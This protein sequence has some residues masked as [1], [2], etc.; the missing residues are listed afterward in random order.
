MLLGIINQFKPDYLAACYDLA[1][2]TFRKAA[3]DGYKAGRKKADEELVSQMVRSRDIF[4]AFGIPIYEKGGFEAD[5]IIGTIVEQTK[6]D[7][8]L[9][10]VIAS[11]DHDTL[12]LVDG[13]RVTVFTLKKGLNDTILY[14]EAA[15]MERFGFGPERMVDYKGLRGDPSDNIPGIHGIGEKTATDLIQKFGSI[16]KIYQ[17]LKKNRAKLIEAGFKERVVKLLE[18]NKEEAEFSKTLATIRRDVPIDFVLP[19]KVW[20]ESYQVDRVVELFRAL[21]FRTLIERVKKIGV[22]PADLAEAPAPAPESFDPKLF[23]QAQVATWLLNSD[24]TNV[25]MAEVLEFSKENNLESAL[26]KLEKQID[27][28]GLAKVYREIELP[29]SPVLRAMEGRGIVIDVSYL[30]KLSKDYRARLNLLEKKIY[31]LA[32]QEFNIKSPRQIGEIL[33][34]KLGVS[35]TG[36]KKTP[37]GA[38]S[39]RESEL[40][41]LRDRHEIIPEILK[42]RELAKLL[43]TYIDNLPGLVGSDGALHTTYN[44]TGS[45][46]GRLSSSNPNLQNL[47]TDP[48]LGLPVRRAFVARPGHTFLAF[49]YSQIEM[50]VLAILSSDGSLQKIFKDGADI[51]TGV[52]ARVFGVD[53]KEVTKEMRRRAKVINF[54]II[55]G[56]GVNALKVNLGSTRDEAAVFLRKYF[57]TFPTIQAYFERV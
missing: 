53:E 13:K 11:G 40:V 28:A 15:V 14:D 19:E 39:T 41:K 52:A 31:E 38:R 50:R 29:L 2:T 51:H 23:C 44:Q 6:K 55:Y 27:E 54:G 18:E 36:V 12:Q 3:F 47:P 37:G 24:L 33:F 7:D 35:T 4:E 34:D 16:E 9:R 26:A 48:E 25:T 20:L 42:H 22:A 45:T 56:M 43:S 32:G 1:E 30:K 8:G 17:T 21:E 46:T 5:D 49:D 10:V 57:E